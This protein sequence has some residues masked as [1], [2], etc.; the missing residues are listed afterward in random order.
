MN[1]QNKTT[2]KIL[3]LRESMTIDEICSLI[4]ITKPTYYSRL[5]RN[6]WKKSE[7]HLI[8]NYKLKK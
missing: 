7:K 5:K 3:K 4:G 6:N 1:T 2:D 8:N